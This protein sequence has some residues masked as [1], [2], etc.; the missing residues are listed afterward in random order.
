MADPHPRSTA[1]F[2][3][4]NT[5]STIVS[6]FS[7]KEAVPRLAKRSIG[8]ILMDAGR[9]SPEQAEQ[10]LAFQQEHG[11]HF[12]EAAVRLGVATHADVEFALS[13]QFEYPY[14]LR[15]ES[16]VD[17]SV[18]AAYDPFSAEVEALRALR[19]QLLL[20]LIHADRRRSRLA[21]VSSERGDGR[22]YLAANLAVVF[23]QL[24]EKTLLI[25]ADMRRP[26][27]HTLFGLENR[28]GLSSMLSGRAGFEAI[29][30]V[31][32]LMD[33]SLV[34]SGSTP[35]NP[36]ELLGRPVFTHLLDQMSNEYNVVIIDTPPGSK[37]AESL[38]IASRAGAAVV[39]ARRN[40][41]RLAGVRD[42]AQSLTHA[43]IAVVGAV[44][45]E[46]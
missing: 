32:S 10:V 20:R 38:T 11:L 23:S 31:P 43:R 18:I 16:L 29:Q 9:M 46:F 40:V 12:G 41:S 42:I 7:S 37:H 21:I 44:L 24:G 34:T 36:Q 3:R 39:V 4:D 1:I 6:A 2:S 35:P 22:S 17:P 19:T 8:V 14:L 15:G 33:L 28:V 45:N 30:R 5:Y 13:Q 26:R 25:D 27:Q